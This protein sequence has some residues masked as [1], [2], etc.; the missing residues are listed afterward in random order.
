MVMTRVIMTLFLAGILWGKVQVVTSTT[1]L[2]DIAETIGG[3]RV[4]LTSIARG[5]QDPHYVE[6]LP[7]YMMK[8]RKADLYLQ[9]GME[10]DLW[11]QRIID[12]SRN[13]KIR[14]VDC[15]R[16]IGALEVPTQKVDASMG[17]IHRFG[18]PHYWLDPANG[19]VIARTIAEAL[20]AVDPAG[21]EEFEANLAVFE[22]AVDQRLASW[23]E[24]YAVL[25]G[26]KIIFY[27]NSWPYFAG[28]FGLETVQFLEPKPGIQPSPA[29]LDRLLDI[30]ESGGIEVLGMES[31][32]SDLAPEFLAGKTELRVVK[33]AQSVGA[34]PGAE[35]YL[36]LFEHNLRALAAAW[37]D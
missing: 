5:N 7:S 19:K 21:Q 24:A 13:R 18:N 9:V 26:Q 1:D 23:L 28:R 8:V 3:D 30:I 17:D 27:H 31:Y 6:I 34:L 36:D 35:S 16:D 20:A 32:F 11:S 15:S 22:L 2:K 12:G 29:H 10:L 33:L 25:K 4:V 14:I 37:G